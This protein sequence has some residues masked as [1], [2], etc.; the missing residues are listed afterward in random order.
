M[1]V[2][3]EQLRKIEKPGLIWGTW[4]DRGYFVKLTIRLTGDERKVVRDRRFGLWSHSLFRVP[5][6]AQDMRDERTPE[7]GKGVTI[8]ELC[9]P[10]GYIL[11]FDNHSDANI[12]IDE[13]RT[14]LNTF[15]TLI[16]ERRSLIDEHNRFGGK[17]EFEL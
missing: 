1:R 2:S 14:H 11:K 12:W 5:R 4:K 7:T 15:K 16:D 3:I 10:D 8:R 13:L 6:T 17:E 9:N